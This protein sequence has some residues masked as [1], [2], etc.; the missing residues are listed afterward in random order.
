MCR[1]IIERYY[2]RSKQWTKTIIGLPDC[3]LYYRKKIIPWMDN[4]LVFRRQNLELNLNSPRKYQISK[5]WSQKHT[6]IN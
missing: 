4:F 1:I 2:H 5:Y 3:P 6:K